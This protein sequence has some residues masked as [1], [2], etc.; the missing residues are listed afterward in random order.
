MRPGKDVCAVAE[1]LQNQDYGAVAVVAPVPAVVSG[2]LRVQAAQD[3]PLDA[4]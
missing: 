2:G 4:T 1:L 3:L